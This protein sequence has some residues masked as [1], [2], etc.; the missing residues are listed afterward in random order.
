[1]NFRTHRVF[2]WGIWVLL[3]M[4]LGPGRVE[5][6]ELTGTDI[7]SLTHLD[8]DYDGITGYYELGFGEIAALDE[9]RRMD[10]DGDGRISVYEVEA[11]AAVKGAEL[12]PNLTLEIDGEA[13]S[14][15]LGELEMITEDPL[16]APVQMTLRFALVPIKRS[17]TAE[18]TLSFTDANSFPRLIHAD[19]SIEGLDLV[20]LEDVQPHDGA[21]KHVR[22]EA[23]RAPAR[24]DVRLVPSATWSGPFAGERSTR[25]ASSRSAEAGVMYTDRLTQVLRADRV[26]PHVMLITLG[27]AV[28]LGAVHALQPGH[29]KTIVAAYLIGSRGTVA[30]AIFLGGVVTFTHTFSIMILGVVTLF[31]SRYILPEQIFP[32]LGTGS[33]FL[34]MALGIWLFVHYVRGGHGHSHG[35]GG[36][37]HLPPELMESEEAPQTHPHHEHAHDDEHSRDHDHGHAHDHE[38]EHD[39]DHGHS[40]DHDH[41]HSHDHDHDHDHEHEHEH[42]HAVK[43]A[44]PEAASA[45]VHAGHGAASGHHAQ[46]AAERRL[47]LSSLLA[48]GVAGGIV[49]CPG[50]LVILLLAVALNRIVLGLSL[51]VAFS[52]GLALVLIIIGVLMVKARPLMEK[53]SGRG[54]LIQ[55]LPVVSAVVIVAAGFAMALRSLM[56]AGI[57]IINL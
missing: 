12:E 24:A 42:S 39:H 55:A 56:E 53:F 51:I 36:H 48:L 31:A 37:Q 29:G 18:H 7:S 21:L 47:K 27:V 14:V 6:H 52:M 10:A 30:N 17:F 40:H 44:H 5:T 16:V 43:G 13:T 57:V 32:W 19:I 28:F 3:A 54:R 26:S 46:S 4:L 22:V 11:Y 2:G 20:D 45:T 49:P 33:G 1:M 35:P 15:R 38:H 8:V 23:P 25:T 50:A 41:D 9:R 34:V